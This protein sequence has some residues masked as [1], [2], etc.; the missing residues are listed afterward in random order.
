MLDDQNPDGDD[1]FDSLVA[2]D[3]VNHQILFGC[4]ISAG[5]EKLCRAYASGSSGPIDSV[6]VVS[7][8]SGSE[9]VSDG[10]SSNK[11]DFVIDPNRGRFYFEASQNAFRLTLT[12]TSSQPIVSSDGLMGGGHN[13]AHLH[14]FR[15]IENSGIVYINACGVNGGNFCL[16]V[17][18]DAS[19]TPASQIAMLAGTGLNYTRAHSNQ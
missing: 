7:N 19:V 15:L 18:V 13:I 6:E 1:V 8:I 17:R 2:Y 4:F 9:T 14:N 5:V 16:L 11:N 3:N 10:L 12:H